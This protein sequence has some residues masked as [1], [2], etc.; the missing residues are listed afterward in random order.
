MQLQRENKITVYT[1]TELGTADVS[2]IKEMLEGVEREGL[3][4]KYT[5]FLNDFIGSATKAE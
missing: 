3:Q 4:E 1:I 2:T 5:G